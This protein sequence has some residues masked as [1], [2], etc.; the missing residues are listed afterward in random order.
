MGIWYVKRHI[1]MNTAPLVFLWR[2]AEIIAASL[3]EILRGS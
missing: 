1:G 2:N 3:Y